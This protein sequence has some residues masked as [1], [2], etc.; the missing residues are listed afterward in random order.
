MMNDTSTIQGKIAVMQAFAD[1]KQI[2][3]YNH[4]CEDWEQ[5]T[6]PCWDWSST[7]YRIYE[8]PVIQ[9]EIPW[10]AIDPKWKYH[11]FNKQARG[12]FMTECPT[13]TSDG[14]WDISKG[15][16][17]SSVLFVIKRGNQPWDK[18]LVKRPEGV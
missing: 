8:K 5:I 3:Y 12:F 13:R 14:L 7:D 18:S 9:D 2:E 1:G 15:S 4:S 16:F 17:A 11:F 6:R 10:A